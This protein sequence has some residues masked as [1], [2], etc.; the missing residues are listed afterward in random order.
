MTIKLNGERRETTARTIAELLQEL[1]APP[2]GIAVAVNG[3]VVRKA[4]HAAT[5]LRENDDVEVIRAVQGG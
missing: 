5:A 4:E 2:I 3:H 1:D